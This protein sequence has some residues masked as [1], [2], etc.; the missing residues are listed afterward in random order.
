MM[1]APGVSL[2]QLHTNDSFE[3]VYEWYRARVNPENVVK[4]DSN[5]VLKSKGLK[6]IINDAGEGTNILL[7]QGDESDVDEYQ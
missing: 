1:R 5:A 7:K 6:I 4:L 2:L 3:K